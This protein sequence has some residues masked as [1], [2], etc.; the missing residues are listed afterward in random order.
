MSV[1]DS[2]PAGTAPDA[3]EHAP[4]GDAPAG[5]TALVV[6]DMQNSYFELPGLAETRDQVLA[7]VNE[8]IRAAEEGG[9]PVVLVRTEHARDRSTW[10]LNM[11][12]DD[13]GF[14][15][16]GTDQARLLADLEPGG[17]DVLEVVKT[18]DSSFHGTD[19]AERLRDRGVDRLVVCGVSTH[20]CV[21]QT[22]VDAFAHQ[23]RAAVAVDAVA[24]DDAALSAALLRFLHEQLRQPLP[25]QA[26]AVA[27]LRHGGPGE[28]W[29]A[30]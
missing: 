28:A 13:Q 27:M 11:L 19:L 4:T 7:G 12:E 30:A 15:F 20:S 8:L 5:R 6:V 29:P 3:P 23:F 25:R 21:A 26:D 18:R 1:T 24:S 16:P 22:A 9:S 10:T 14:A 17:D 2:T